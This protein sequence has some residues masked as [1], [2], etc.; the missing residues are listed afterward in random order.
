[1][2]FVYCMIVMVFL[3]LDNWYVVLNV[4]CY[5]CECLSYVGGY[6]DFVLDCFLII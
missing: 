1:M 6:G 3:F 4:L 5:W 2:C